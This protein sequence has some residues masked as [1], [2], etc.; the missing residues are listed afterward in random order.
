[1]G[2]VGLHVRLP[3]S[4]EVIKKFLDTKLSSKTEP[5]QVKELYCE[6]MELYIGQGRD[7]VA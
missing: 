4:R 3:S 5:R 2:Q 1:M 6:L 7:K